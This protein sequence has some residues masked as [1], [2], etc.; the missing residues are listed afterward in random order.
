MQGHYYMTLWTIWHYLTES[1]EAFA[2]SDQKTEM[3]AKL[4]MENIVCW[5]RIPE[6]LLSNRGP[7][8]LSELIQEMCK[9]L[10]VKKINTSCHHSQTDGLVENFNSTLIN[11]QVLWC[12][13]AWLGCSCTECHLKNLRGKHHFFCCKE[14]ML[15]FRHRLYCLIPAALMLLIFITIQGR[16]NVWDGTGLETHIGE[17][18]NLHKGRLMIVTEYIGQLIWLISFPDGNYRSG[19]M[20]VMNWFLTLNYLVPV[21]FCHYLSFP[22]CY[23]CMTW[24]FII[25]WY[26]LSFFNN[27]QDIAPE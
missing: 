10:G 15:V 5:H 14:G 16:F 11:S 6:D 21:C 1:P 17:K 13:K 2:I 25:F 18:L 3:I 20:Y 22:F 8:F 12:S 9:L 7:N 24:T 4:F 23:F 19:V 27:V 26:S